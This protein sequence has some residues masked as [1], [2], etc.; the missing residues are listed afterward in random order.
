MSKQIK[1][2]EYP[3]FY[4]IC[5]WGNENVTSWAPGMAQSWRTT[6]DIQFGTD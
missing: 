2:T 6:I 4:A 5:N 3:T 1:A